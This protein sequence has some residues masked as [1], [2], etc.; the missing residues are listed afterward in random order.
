MKPPL[1]GDGIPDAPAR[2][3][4]GTTIP[5]DFLDPAAD[6]RRIELGYERH[7]P[8]GDCRLL[9]GNVGEPIA[10]ELLMIER[11]VGN[12][13][14]EGPLDHVRRVEPPAEANLENA[15]VCRGP[16]ERQKGSS[17]RDL[18]EARLDAHASVD[19]VG[20]QP[21]KLVVPDQSAG[22]ADPLVE[23]DQVRA[24]E[25]V[26]GVAARLERCPDERDGRT[27]SVGSS[28]MENR[29]KCVLWPP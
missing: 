3:P 12:P 5:S 11:E 10:E 15:R 7:S 8:L 29:W 6:C 2:N 22:D 28:D 26:N 27:L 19:H 24:G 17:C 4:V 13:G 16:G 23:P 21:C 18:E 1:P 9:A 25:G 14:D 20:E